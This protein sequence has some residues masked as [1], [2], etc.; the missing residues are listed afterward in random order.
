MQNEDQTLTQKVEKL[1]ENGEHSDFIKEQMNQIVN[2]W[3][4]NQMIVVYILTKLIL[5]MAD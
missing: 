3:T 4:L 5:K 1:Q 2:Q